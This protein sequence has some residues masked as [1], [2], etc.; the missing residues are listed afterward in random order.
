[1][2]DTGRVWFPVGELHRRSVRE[3]LEACEL[4]GDRPLLQP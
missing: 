4:L 2:I 1:M 3:L